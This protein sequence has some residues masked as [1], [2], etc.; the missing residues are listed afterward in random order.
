MRSA[1][2]TINSYPP[3]IRGL[4]LLMFVALLANCSGPFCS[5]LI[6]RTKLRQVVESRMEES[7]PD[8]LLIVFHLPESSTA[9]FHWTR[10]G[11]EFVF[12]DEMYDV[13][14]IKNENGRK[15]F[16][17]L[18]DTLEKKLISDYAKR[19]TNSRN[20]VRHIR[21]LTISWID[22]TMVYIHLATATEV[23]YI[24]WSDDFKSEAREILS[25]PPEEEFI[26]FLFTA[27]EL[28]NV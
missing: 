15:V 11:K 1:P 9:D 23:Q 22:S 28:Q 3:V 27:S 26:H 14:R 16:L 4:S 7:L 12:H 17:C 10:E 25:P 2:F 19:E 20:P 18:K 13:V 8:S 24:T 6:C 5:F 21:S